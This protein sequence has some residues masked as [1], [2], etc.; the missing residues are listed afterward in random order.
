MKL[1]VFSR[2]PEESL[3]RENFRQL[4]VNKELHDKNTRLKEQ[5]IYLEDN[6]KK[7]TDAYNKS[8]SDL[9]DVQQEIH[10]LKSVPKENHS[11]QRF[12]ITSKRGPKKKST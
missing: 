11:Q 12:E 7:M 9:S 6:Y 10:R 3:R 5:L 8:M 4:A 2:C 1:H